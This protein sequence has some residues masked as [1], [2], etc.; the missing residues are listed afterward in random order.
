MIDSEPVE[1]RRQEP[2]DAADVA[3]VLRAAFAAEPEVVDLEPALAA[4]SDS[5]GFVAV[6]DGEVVGHVRITRG[7]V[8]ADAALVT[9]QVLS[10]LSV[11][12]GYQSRGIGRALVAR[13]IEEAERGGAPVILLEGDPGY[14]SRLGWRPAA[15]LGITPPSPR[16]P[17][18][19]CQ[20]VRLS[21]Y[22]PWMRGPLVY[23]DTFWEHD[24][25]GLRGADLDRAIS[26]L[27]S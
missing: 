14:Y 22:E 17:A 23:A 27:G 2:A 15:E 5:A 20:G 12:P 11:H 6:V 1:V 24:A 19:A 4:R 7:W 21:A 16:I 8:D 26:R 25:V 3:R 9:V 18:R 10:P 13:A